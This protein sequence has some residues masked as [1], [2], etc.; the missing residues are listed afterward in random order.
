MVLTAD[1]SYSAKQ[2]PTLPSLAAVAEEE[3]QLPILTT[4]PPHV[5]PIQPIMSLHLGHVTRTDQ[6]EE[7]IRSNRGDET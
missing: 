2:V 6:S 5:T 3:G 4:S 7:S 1:C